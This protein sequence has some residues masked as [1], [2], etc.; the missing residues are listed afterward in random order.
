MAIDLELQWFRGLAELRFAATPKRIRALL[1][2]QT[3]LDTRDAL[4]VYEPRRIVPWYAVP[5]ADLRMNLSEH[6]PSPA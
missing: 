6:D 3:V 4:L 1:D 5:P 2:G